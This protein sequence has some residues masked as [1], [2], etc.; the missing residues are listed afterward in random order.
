[1]NSLRRLLVV[2]HV[3]HYRHG[4][5]LFAYGPYTREID[6]W[7]DLFPELVIAAPCRDEKPPG[8]CIAFTRPNISIAPQ[9]EAGGDN[10]Q[11]K[12][13]QVLSLPGLVWDLSR[14][15]RAADAIHVRCPG[16]LG[17]LGVLLAPLFSRRLVAKYA[18]QWNGYPGERFALRL[19]R[20]VLRSRWWHGP[21][22][23]YGQWPNEPAQ[24]VAFF[25]S[26][27]TDEMVEHAT[28]VAKTKSI[29]QPLRVL[30]SGR[31]A[32]EK[33]VAALLDATKIL[34]ERGVSLEVALVGGGSEEAVLRKHTADLELQDHVRFVGS[35]PFETSLRWCEW[36]HC[37]VLPSANS[38]GWPKVI[39]EGMCYGLVCIGVEHGQ[40]PR[41]LE[42]RGIVLKSGTPREIA[43][44]LQ[45]IAERPEEFDVMRQQASTW[46]RQYSLDGLRE[47][48]RDVLNRHWEVSLPSPKTRVSQK[49]CGVYESNRCTASL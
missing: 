1:M 18:G 20:G 43:D 9:R 32:P 8:D 3:Q 2:S 15:M 17:V 42:G 41:M 10:W 40:V 26:M 12:V 29:G 14:Q 16:N 39:A 13:R 4:G 24:V 5:K 44:A 47:A 21:V 28:Q 22:T 30:F 36:A 11:A 45:R 33:R 35:L 49:A 19:Q 38:E 34:V 31:L 37:L 46:A 48:L 25:T 23:V 6:V 7:A 27:M